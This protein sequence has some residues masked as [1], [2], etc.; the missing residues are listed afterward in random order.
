[1]QL[2]SRQPTENMT[3]EVIP[4][5]SSMEAFRPQNGHGFNSGFPGLSVLV[6]APSS[7]IPAGFC[8]IFVGV[9]LVS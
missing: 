2:S 3:G 1:M 4:C 6:I 7:P 8:L 5:V 9:L